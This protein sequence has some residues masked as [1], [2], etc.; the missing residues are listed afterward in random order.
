MGA[1]LD[2]KHATYKDRICR[3]YRL[4]VICGVL[5]YSNGLRDITHMTKPVANSSVSVRQ[6]V[7]INLCNA[8][9]EHLSLRA[10]ATSDTDYSALALTCFCSL[11]Q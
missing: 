1:R 6:F 4:S 7:S 5:G 3:Q 10:T 8:T 2:D 9:Q 11:L